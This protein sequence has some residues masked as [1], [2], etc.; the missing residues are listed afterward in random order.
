MR[1]GRGGHA[2]AAHYRLDRKST[3][4][5]SSHMSISYAVFCLKKKTLHHHVRLGPLGH[6]REVLLVDVLHDA[7]PLARRALGALV[8]RGDL[9]RIAR[10]SFSPDVTVRA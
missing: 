10:R 9:D 8:V 6:V 4:L 5:N 3:R 1:C 7:H 2:W